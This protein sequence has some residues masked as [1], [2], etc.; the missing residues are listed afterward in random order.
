MYIEMSSRTENYFEIAIL[1]F[2]FRAIFG[3]EG[4]RLSRS[5]VRTCQNNQETTFQNRIYPESPGNSMNG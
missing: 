1:A 5:D 3:I 4:K 2:D